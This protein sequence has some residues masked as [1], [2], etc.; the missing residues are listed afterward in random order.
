M[1]QILWGKLVL[2][3]VAIVA[4]L[5]VVHLV[6][7]SRLEARHHMH[8][9]IHRTAAN[10]GDS[11]D[12]QITEVDAVFGTLVR[13]VEQGRVLDSS[14]EFQI[15]PSIAAATKQPHPRG[16][17]AS[18][19]DIS[20]VTQCSFNHVYRLI[21]LTQRWQ[22]PISVA[23]FAEDHQVSEALWKVA[24]LRACLPGIRHNVTFALVSPLPA[25]S[26]PPLSMP[27]PPP[28][29]PCSL[30]H[31][32]DTTTTNYATTHNYPVNLLR[33]VARRG[34]A[35]EF[36]LVVDID[37]LPNENLRQDFFAFASQRGLFRKREHDEKN[38][39][40]VPAFEAKEETPVPRHKAELLKLVDSGDMRPF[41]VQLCLK[42]QVHT[43]YESWQKEPPA[44]ELAPLFEVL[45]KDPWEPF[46][47]A[48]NTIPFYDERFKQYGFNRI[49]QVCELHVAG[50]KFSV[51]NN[52]FL[53]HQ[54]VKTHSS[55]HADKDAELERNRMLFRQFKME[56]KSKYPESSRRC[57]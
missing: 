31:D 29:H 36:V 37:M 17:I 42:C 7:L 40:V 3:L 27:S 10:Q 26:S 16:L 33:N 24:E 30:K 44:A 38:V 2:V 18:T 57:Y 23:V 50:Y 43:D 6:L 34:T 52:A 1:Q 45:W 48:R 51:L 5:Q 47:I 14:G 55:F 8:H 19:P 28:P 46:Y 54:G 15:V 49:S 20:I 32:L 22:G 39:F 21:A 11:S 12:S 56:L 35:S 25:K 9:H 41:Y 53:V 4:V 13:T